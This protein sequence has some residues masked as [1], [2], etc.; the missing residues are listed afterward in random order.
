MGCRV[1]GDTI[2]MIEPVEKLL[3]RQLGVEQLM[4]LDGVE[5]EPRLHPVIVFLRCNINPLG[6]IAGVAGKRARAPFA[7]QVL[8]HDGAGPPGLALGTALQQRART[9]T[10]DDWSSPENQAL[11]LSIDKRLALLR[12][13]LLQQGAAAER[14]LATLL[15]ERAVGAYG[16]KSGF[17]QAARG[18]NLKSYQA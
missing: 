6:G 17:G 7:R 3:G 4:R 12:K 8:H 9:P 2:L 5:Q 18:P 15:P 11:A 14:A 16:D 13:T 1:S 10:K